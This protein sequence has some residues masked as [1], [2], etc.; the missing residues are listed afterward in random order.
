MGHSE[1]GW[2]GEGAQEIRSLGLR[3]FRA[4]ECVYKSQASC[5]SSGRWAGSGALWPKSRQ[6]AG[7]ALLPR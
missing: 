2:A 3:E 7:C 1:I 5:L 4:P 6:L